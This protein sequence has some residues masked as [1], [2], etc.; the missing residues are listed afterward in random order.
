MSACLA[1]ATP[2]RVSDKASANLD[3]L[4]NCFRQFCEIKAFKFSI[5]CKPVLK[6]ISGSASVRLS[7]VWGHSVMNVYLFPI[8]FLFSLILLLCPHPC[9][10]HYAY[11][12][13]PY[14]ILYVPF[15]FFI[16][17]QTLSIHYLSITFL[18]PF[19]RFDQMYHSY[20]SQ[21]FLIIP[22][23]SLHSI[24]FFIPLSSDPVRP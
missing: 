5:A 3:K 4:S 19:L 13:C 10:Y 18:Q 23:L 22:L 16:P 15:L 14:P 7:W 9:L 1:F 17:N 21:S 11:A 12:I 24:I 20:C 6:N 2:G 8:Y